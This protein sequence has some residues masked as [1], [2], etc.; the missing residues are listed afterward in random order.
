MAIYLSNLMRNGA[1][2]F[3]GE[4]EGELDGFTAVYKVSAGQ[5]LALNDQIKLARIFK[6]VPLDTIVVRAGDLDSNASPTITASLGYTRAVKNPALAYNADSNPAVT[7]SVAADSLA[8]YAAASATPFQAGGVN[9]Y[10]RGQTALD[11]E[12]ANN[13]PVDGFYDLTLTITAAAAT[14]PATD[15]YIYVSVEHQGLT[16]TPGNLAYQPGVNPYV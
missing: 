11:N 12:F 2:P 7:D 1:L 9:R 15:Q 10:V 14:A 4:Y 8:Y 6:N 16:A 13:G 3:Q 5:T